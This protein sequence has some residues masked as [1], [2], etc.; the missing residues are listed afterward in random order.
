MK[1]FR[2][3]MEKPGLYLADDL[4]GNGAAISG[5]RWNPK[6]R[7]VLYSCCNASTAVLETLVHLSGLLPAGGFFLVTLDMP[8]VAFENA[9]QPEL[10]PDWA[11]LD[12]DPGT[13]AEIGRQWLERGEQLAMRVP[14][15]VCQAD[16]NLLLN[17]LHPEMSSVRVIRKEP[18]KIDPRLFS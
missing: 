18:F 1:V 3:A 4:S 8:D 12:R 16:F 14:S 10:P 2:L 15:V 13:T 7:R 17:P 5:G 11:E 9:Y 6:G